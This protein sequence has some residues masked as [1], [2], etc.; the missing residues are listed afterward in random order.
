MINIKTDARLKSQAK[1]VA[2]R[3]GFSL[4]ALIKGYLKH[5]VKSKTVY[6]TT[7]EEP[8]AYMIQALKEAEEDRK[9]GRVSPSFDNA[10]DA[11]AW[12]RKKK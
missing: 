8:N 2:E 6:F 1:R 10:D 7:R 3:L 11:I 5:L 4:S 9:T 12:L